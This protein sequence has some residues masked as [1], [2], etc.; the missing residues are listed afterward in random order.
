[1][2][3]KIDTKP[4]YTVITPVDSSMDANMTAALRQKW[5]VLAESGSGNAI[6]DLSCCTA[7]DESA[8]VQL[9]E[10]HEEVYGN[11]QS[12]VFTNLQPAVWTVVKQKEADLLLNIAPTM[13]EAV[14]IISMEIL[15]RELFDEES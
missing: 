11:N 2:E 7:A 8:F 5:K 1:M 4:T 13:Q 3:F 6:I 12:I 9:G 10:L 14:D 15:E